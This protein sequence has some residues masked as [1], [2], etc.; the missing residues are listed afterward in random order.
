MPEEQ[1]TPVKKLQPQVIELIY[2]DL[3]QRFHLPHDHEKPRLE[4]TY[5]K[6]LN[7][8]SPR[9]DLLAMCVVASRYFKK[10]LEV[11]PFSHNNHRI[12]LALALT[13]LR[14]NHIGINCSEFALYKIATDFAFDEA[15]EDE[16]AQFFNDHCH[17]DQPCSQWVITP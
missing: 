6:V 15:N 11:Q 5:G 16:L 9:L 13:F 7:F 17:L 12:A 10:T 1:V 14:S 8:A 4:K 2:D 3:C